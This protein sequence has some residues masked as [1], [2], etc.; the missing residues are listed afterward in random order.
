MTT[1]HLATA[2]AVCTVAARFLLKA[3]LFTLALAL[4]L[5]GIEPTTASDPA[6]TQ[7]P[8]QPDSPARVVVQAQAA[9]LAPCSVAAPPLATLTVLQLRTL[10]RA[11][12]GASAR[13][14]GRRIASATRA[15]L[16]QALAG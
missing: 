14:G 10:A 5:G 3:L 7:A 9:A 11:Q 16:L 4:L 6:P 12:L 1:R 8:P 2:A 15:A 13:P